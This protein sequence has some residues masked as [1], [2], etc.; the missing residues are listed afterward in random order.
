M[1]E[2][3]VDYVK[4]STV[5]TADPARDLF[6]DRGF[7]SGGQDLTVSRAPNA[8]CLRHRDGNWWLDNDSGDPNEALVRVW[9]GLDNRRLDVPARL[10]F[11][12]P[13][14]ENEVRIFKPEYAVV[15]TVTGSRSLGGRV[16][17]P[18]V[19]EVG[20]PEA[21]VHVRALFHQKPRTKVVL[22]A[23][24]REYLTPGFAA[25]KPLTRHQ[26]S[27][28][29]GNSNPHEVDAALKDIQAAIWGKQG[30]GESV[31]QFLIN[32]KL[33]ASVDQQLVPHRICPHRRPGVA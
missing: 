12:L 33:L 16:A 26:A 5:F 24:Y 29:L 28:C 1:A 15:L 4:F 9:T 32:R 7:L 25:P 21:V 10:S 6:L 17:D 20:L 8:P 14:G 13:E 23:L 22:A 31:P 19:T 18:K 2:L 27:E 11:R 3:K 30:N